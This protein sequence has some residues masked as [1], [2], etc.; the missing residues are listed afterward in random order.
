MIKISGLHNFLYLWTRH[1]D[2]LSQF[3]RRGVSDRYRGSALGFAWA[4]LTP[5][6]LLAT[7]TF[8]FGVIF[9]ARWGLD[10]NEGLG[11]F[12]LVLFTGL[13][14]F[15][16]F[17]DPIVAAPA[18]LRRYPNFIK[19]VVFPLEVLGISSVASAVIH[20]L[21]SLM[22]VIVGALALHHSLH[23]TIIYLPLYYLPLAFLTIGLC[24]F[25]SALGLFLRDLVHLIGLLVQLLMFLSPIFYPVRIVPP[26]LRWVFELNPLSVIIEGFRRSILWGQFPE[27]AALAWLWPVSLLVLCLGYWIFSRL[28][29][30]FADVL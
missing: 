3:T 29:P 12:A 8:V 21:F 16:V 6:A 14:A 4:L 10:E 27:W 30:G 26:R 5:L 20:S 23:W 15:N 28:K 24:W 2:L 18:L 9:K 17:S 7:Y 19:K 25:L 13:I 1:Y 11:D 22:I